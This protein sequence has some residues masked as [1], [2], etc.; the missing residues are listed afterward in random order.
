MIKYQSKFENFINGVDFTAADPCIWVV[1]PVG[2][3]GDLL[4]S[5]VNFHY[6]V[7]GCYYFGLTNRGQVIHNLLT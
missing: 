5:I 4:A 1:Y 7:T 3:A 6:G 2:A